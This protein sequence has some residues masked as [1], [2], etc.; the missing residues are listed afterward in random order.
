M[1][2]DTAADPLLDALS[3]PVLRLDAAGTITHANRATGQWLGVGRRRLLGLP[4]SSL[5]RDSQR[6]ASAL[7]QASEQASRLRRM[8]L[9]FPGRDDLHFA[10]LLLS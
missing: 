10:D 3:T 8:P 6:L 4:A 9:A 1:H 5:E 2:L 7:Q